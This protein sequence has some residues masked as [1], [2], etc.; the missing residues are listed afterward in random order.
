[1]SVVVAACAAVFYDVFYDGFLC[2][3]G[4]T[5]PER[6]RSV[7]ERKN[8]IFCNFL[9]DFVGIFCYLLVY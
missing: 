6:K 4:R 1:M 5:R 3:G 7:E 9:L 2:G 8:N